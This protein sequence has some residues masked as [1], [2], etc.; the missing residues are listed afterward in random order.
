MLTPEVNLNSPETLTLQAEETREVE[1]ANRLP[2]LLARGW[3]VTV[4]DAVD[5]AEGFRRHLRMENNR[6]LEESN[7]STGML[8]PNRESTQIRLISLVSGSFSI[9]RGGWSI[10]PNLLL[11]SKLLIS[12]VYSIVILVDW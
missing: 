12:V 6:G 4:R 1:R 9:D 5:G 2:Q 11:I 3:S 8:N 10:M 7:N